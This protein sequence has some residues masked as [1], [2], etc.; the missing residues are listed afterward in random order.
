MAT[1]VSPAVSNSI[2][3][4]SSYL[5]ILDAK[6]QYESKTAILDTAQDRV[7]YDPQAH[8]FNLQAEMEDGTAGP[9]CAHA[10]QAAEGQK[11]SVP[12][13]WE[14]CSSDHCWSS[15]AA[16]PEEEAPR[17]AVLHHL[18]HFSAAGRREQCSPHPT[19]PACLTCPPRP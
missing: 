15:Y 18:T 11:W 6:Y 2:G 3:L 8:T 1:T 14:E 16:A 7:L 9:R 13:L 4:A 17:Q 19:A 12:R 10:G 5:P